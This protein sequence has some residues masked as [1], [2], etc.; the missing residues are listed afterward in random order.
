MTE[1]EELGHYSE[2][3]ELQEAAEAAQ[4]ARAV[5]TSDKEDYVKDPEEDPVDESQP[6]PASQI[7]ANGTPAAPNT[8]VSG[9]S[10]VNN[11]PPVAGNGTDEPETPAPAATGN[12][13]IDAQERLREAVGQYGRDIGTAQDLLQREL[14]L[15]ATDRNNA[16]KSADE[17]YNAALQQSQRGGAQMLLDYAEQLRKAQEE[18]TDKTAAEQNAVR[19][20]GATE[21][22]AAIANMIGVGSFNAVNQ[23]YHSYSQDWMK[24]ADADMKARRA[25]IDNLRER[26]RA[27]QRQ[28]DQVRLQQAGQARSDARRLADAA[29]QQKAAAANANYNTLIKQAAQRLDAEKD[30]INIALKGQAAEDTKADRAA[31][32]SIQWA[33]LNAQN[34]RHAAELNAKGYNPD[35]SVNEEQLRKVEEIKQSAKGGAGKSAVKVSIPHPDKPGRGVTLSFKNFRSL[36]STIMA[37]LDQFDDDDRAAIEDIISGEGSQDEK[38]KA[39]QR[40]ISK[41]PGVYRM[42]ERSADGTEE[43]D[44]SSTNN[45][46]GR[47]DK[48]DKKNSKGRKEERE[49]PDLNKYK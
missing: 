25:R 41:N 49:S 20:T 37:N 9:G 38:A 46:A 36:L 15:A 31:G 1:P 7:P 26:Q 3:E 47:E 24:K 2:M 42:L 17:P 16:Y 10:A 13:Y 4:A 5:A 14:G 39:L 11:Q 19:W 27:I 21:L 33:S 29:Y 43:Y 18:D 12:V 48:Q 40:Y 22:A 35:G 6:S 45:K 8:Q 32:R 44:M 34:D 28:M 23:Q 30:A